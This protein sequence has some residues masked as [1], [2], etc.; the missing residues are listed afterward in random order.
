[1]KSYISR[2]L[3]LTTRNTD[4][5]F[6]SFAGVACD[7]VDM[8]ISKIRGPNPLL[9][10]HEPTGSWRRSGRNSPN[11]SV[12]FT[13]QIRWKTLEISAQ[14]QKNRGIVVN[15]EA[16]KIVYRRDITVGT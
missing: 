8:T 3:P 6:D 16:T 14:T 11:A 4:F 2:K 5:A 12:S 9:A 10:G 1:M 13:F 7:G 15:H